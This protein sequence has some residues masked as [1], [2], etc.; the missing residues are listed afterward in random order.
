MHPIN[1]ILSYS[2]WQLYKSRR[3]ANFPKGFMAKYRRDLKTLKAS[4]PVG[5]DIASE[6]LYESGEHPENYI[7]YECAFA[8]RHLNRLSP[9][10]VLDIGSYRH[11]ILG[12][13][14][15]FKV[16]T[17][18]IRD[19]KPVCENEIL[20]TC[21]AKDLKLPDLS[22]DVVIS[23]CSVEHFGLGRYG[24][25]IDFEADKK[26]LKEMTRVLKS[27]GHL[28]FSTELARV[29]QPIIVFNT[30]RI[31]TYDSIVK[32][33]DEFGFI[34]EDENFFSR[35][36]NKPC[37]QREILTDPIKHK[38]QDVYLGCWKKK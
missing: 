4:P 25:E 35:L 22:F 16:T 11:F 30:H 19:R 9:V 34:K 17:I 20:I 5:F 21:D 18:D 2:G 10:S 15:H 23:L 7:D 32:I 13:L 26:A 37:E 29:P 12:L 28:I 27:G 31:Y 6:I 8:A 38:T 33:R 3:Q 24:D 14:S 36:L 1:K